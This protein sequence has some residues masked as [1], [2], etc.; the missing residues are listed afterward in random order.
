MISYVEKLRIAFA[1]EEGFIDP[2]KFKSSID[3]A[4]EIMFNAAIHSPN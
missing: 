4:F 2:Q 1:L 3:N